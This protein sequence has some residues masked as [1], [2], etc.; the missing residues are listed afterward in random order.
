MAVTFG[1]LST[2]RAGGLTEA[3]N[4]TLTGD[5]S[6]VAHQSIANGW[7]GVLTT[8]TSA[9]VGTI[10]MDDS[11]HGMTNGDRVDL[12]WITGMR[13][14]VTVGA[15]SGAAIPIS[16]GDGDD[17][18]TTSTAITVVPAVEVPF[19]FDG[20]L[21]QALVAYSDQRGQIVIADGSDTELLHIPLG[22]ICS[23]SWY[24]AN[25]AANPLTGDTVAKAFFSHDGS[26]AKDMMLGALYNNA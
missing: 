12:Y 7:D 16:L 13:R 26:A 3:A 23:Y 6:V 9:S 20:D 22:T 8:R 21:L 25:Q 10:T 14:G 4:K 17:L 2:V 15:V 19:E 18:P 1:L 24:E 5:A 11:A